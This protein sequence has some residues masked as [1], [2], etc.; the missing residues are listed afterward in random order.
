VPDDAQSRGWPRSGWNAVSRRSGSAGPV[1]QFLEAS[2]VEGT[3][4]TEHA[5]VG[6]HDDGGRLAE[7]AEA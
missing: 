5:P 1:H 4:V 3:K 6:C 2:L 7:D